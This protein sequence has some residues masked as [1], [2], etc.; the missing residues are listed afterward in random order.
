VGLPDVLPGQLYGYCVHG[1]YQLAQ[2]QRS[3]PYKVVLAPYV[4]L[5]SRDVQ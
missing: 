4:K 2:G 3:N 1:P 5:I